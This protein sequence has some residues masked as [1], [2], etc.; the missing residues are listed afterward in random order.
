MYALLLTVLLLPVVLHAADKE[1]FD[2][3]KT[4]NLAQKIGC[5]EAYFPNGYKDIDKTSHE[6]GMA[7][8]RCFAKAKESRQMKRSDYETRITQFEDERFLSER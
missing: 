6:R 8:A 5:F 7:Y 1:Q 2:D 3:A 4:E